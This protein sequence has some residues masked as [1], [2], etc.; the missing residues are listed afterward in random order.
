[1]GC[2]QAQGGAP[3]SVSVFPQPPHH[4]SPSSLP[5]LLPT[6]KV[7]AGL[8]QPILKG[9]VY[10]VIYHVPLTHRRREQLLGHQE[11]LGKFT[12]STFCKR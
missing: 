7:F 12:M 11:I 1:M 4:T 6:P 8:I 10:I 2:E 3:V 5:P 9:L